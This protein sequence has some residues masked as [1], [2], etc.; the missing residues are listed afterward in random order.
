MSLP[1]YD[2]GHVSQVA[3][4]RFLARV[5]RARRR[6]LLP[7]AAPT[8]AALEKHAARFGPEQVPETASEYGISIAITRAKAKPRRARGASLAQRVAGYLKQGHGVDVI[9]ELE[10]LSPSR[11]RTVVNVALAKEAK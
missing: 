9:A 6:S 3:H 1:G 4:S 7:G 10:N 11:A 2:G 5:C 8:A